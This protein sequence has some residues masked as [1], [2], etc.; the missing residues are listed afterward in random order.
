M[1][2]KKVYILRGPSGAG[3]TTWVK[4]IEAQVTV[5]S[6]DHFF[7]EQITPLEHVDGVRIGYNWDVAKLPEAHAAC[8]TAFLQALMEGHPV[9]AVDN[10][11]SRKWMYHSYELAARLAGYEVEIIE[12]MPVT[13]DEMRLCAERTA[14][15]VPSS[16]IASMV[17]DF[18]PDS[19]ATKVLVRK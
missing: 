15:K 3:K 11:N 8:M 9:I 4:K 18:E 16:V 13:V 1:A 6:A 10:T 17:M 14:H 12:V 5:C 19:R 7:E 2:M